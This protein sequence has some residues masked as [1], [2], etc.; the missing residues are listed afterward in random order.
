MNST[1]PAISN[2]RLYGAA[3]AVVSGIY[4]IASSATAMFG[5]QPMNAM[6]TGMAGMGITGWVMLVVGV[7][8]VI[9]GVI[10]LT[11]VAVSLAKWSGWLML[12][13]ATIML[14]TQLYL[15]FTA[16]QGMPAPAT[17][18]MNWDPGMVAVAVLM[19]VSGLIM[20]PRRAG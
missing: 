16:N 12:L 8:V 1:S 15:A 19:L 2:T 14:L 17:V 9:H 3:I 18:T 7:I 6:D 13:W 10:L 4:S 20:L 11:P 5:T